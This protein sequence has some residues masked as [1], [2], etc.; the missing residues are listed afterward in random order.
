M[1]KPD[2][3]SDKE[4]IK[5]C[6]AGDARA[7]DAL[8]E[9][10]QRLVYSVPMR[11]GV[12][13][14]DA[15]DI[16]QDVFI[17]LFRNLHALR[18]ADKIASWLI[19]TTQ[20]ESW[21]WKKRESKFGSK[22]VHESEKD[23]DI[24]ASLPDNRESPEETALR[25]EAQQT[26]RDALSLLEDRCRELLHLLFYEHPRPSYKNISEALGIPEGAIGPTRARCLKKLKE[27]VARLGGVLGGDT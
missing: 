8:I 18:D 22:V 23:E 7:W 13:P 24:L 12:S 11:Y 1:T 16:M 6:L 9:R 25:M 20:R 17:L 21:R 26:I 4:L 15:A 2:L 19:T 27:A 5:A 3:R 14:D 10:Y